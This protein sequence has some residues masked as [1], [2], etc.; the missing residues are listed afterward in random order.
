MRTA[1]WIRHS[2]CSSSWLRQRLVGYA[3]HPVAGALGV[4]IHETPASGFLI[5]R[6]GGMNPP[7]RL[8]F[9]LAMAA[10]RRVCGTPRGRCAR[11]TFGGRLLRG[12]K[13]RQEGFLSSL[14]LGTLIRVHASAAR[15]FPFAPRSDRK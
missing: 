9:L 6:G 5:A 8:L 13:R 1:D 15:Q 7:L 4:T 3:G 11:R 12:R 10:A 14:L 2:G